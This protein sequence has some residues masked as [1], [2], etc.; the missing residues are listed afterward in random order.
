MVGESNRI[1]KRKGMGVP[2]YSFFHG[3]F[4][5]VEFFASL[6]DVHVVEEVT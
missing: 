3:D 1:L 4:V 5:G 2:V 6:S